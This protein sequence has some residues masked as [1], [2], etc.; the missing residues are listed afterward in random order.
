MVRGDARRAAAREAEAPCGGR[1]CAEL[2]CGGRAT[3]Y[4][5]PCGGRGWTS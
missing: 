1:G 4:I 2:P 5:R 3:N